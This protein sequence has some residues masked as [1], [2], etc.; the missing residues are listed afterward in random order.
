MRTGL[1]GGAIAIYIALVG[2]YT[3][4]ADLELVG[5][6]V[7]LGRVLLVAPALLA[8][9]V[10]TRPRT[11]AGERREVDSGRASSSGR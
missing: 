4:F 2:P 9:Y 10:V 5:D 6:Q 8:G 11:V 1:V 3:R 7:T